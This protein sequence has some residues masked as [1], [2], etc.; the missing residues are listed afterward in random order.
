MAQSKLAAQL[1][2]ATQAAR[3]LN[4][5][6][7][8][9]G[10]IKANYASDMA[11]GGGGGGGTVLGPDGSPAA[12]PNYRPPGRTVRSG[13]NL[14]GPGTI[15]AADI[16]VAGEAERLAELDAAAR[17]FGIPVQV[18]HRAS[19]AEQDRLLAKFRSLGSPGYEGGGA[20]QS[21]GGAGGGGSSGGGSGSSR[22]TASQ[23]HR[24]TAFTSGATNNQPNEGK[25]TAKATVD[26]LGSVVNEL[27][28]LNKTVARK[29]PGMSFR[30]GEI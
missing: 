5:E 9:F 23:E 29:D 8:K 15:T 13:E 20:T 2:E 11:P 17:W 4:S 24:N 16:D 18:I 28:T 22:V 26:A 14:N 12:S 6:A 7:A 10:Q 3:D 30:T 19:R 27:K 1:H 21:G 25:A